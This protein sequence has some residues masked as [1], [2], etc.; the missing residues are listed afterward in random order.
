[1]TTIPTFLRY[2]PTLSHTFPT[3]TPDPRQL[4][5]TPK[6]PSPRPCTYHC[7]LPT[8]YLL[9]T[10]TSYTHHTQ[11][12]KTRDVCFVFFPPRFLDLQLITHPLPHHTAQRLT[13]N[14]PPRSDLTYA[15]PYPYPSHAFPSPAQTSDPYSDCDAACHSTNPISGSR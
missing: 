2:T 13:S 14:Q 11:R 10:T 5:T 12:T 3:P 7:P 8:P 1:M 15:A 4:P 6:T 9:H